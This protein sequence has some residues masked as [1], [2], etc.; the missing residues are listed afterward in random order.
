[1]DKKI[2]QHVNR[3]QPRYSKEFIQ[4]LNIN[5]DPLSDI[6]ICKCGRSIK[7]IRS[8]LLIAHLKTQVHNRWLVNESH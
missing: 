3:I 4:N 2:N 1:M 8:C 7:N 5:D 6:W